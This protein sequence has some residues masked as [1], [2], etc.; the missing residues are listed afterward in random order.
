MH[1]DAY[2][3]IHRVSAPMHARKPGHVFNSLR[4]GLYAVLANRIVLPNN[5]DRVQT[6]NAIEI[7]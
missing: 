4:A 5:Y 2:V 1:I 6:S 3:L 7:H